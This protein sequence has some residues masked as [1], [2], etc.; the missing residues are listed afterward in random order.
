MMITKCCTRCRQDKPRNQFGVRS[1]SRDGLHN[2]CRVC[3][4]ERQKIA[5][6]KLRQVRMAYGLPEVWTRWVSG[7]Q[8]VMN[9]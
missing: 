7:K 1:A 8:P 9:E 4:S 5:L 2:E 6:Q 3:V